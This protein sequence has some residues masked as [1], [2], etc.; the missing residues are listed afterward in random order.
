MPRTPDPGA[1]QYDLRAD[2]VTRRRQPASR[3]F[4]PTLRKRL[5]HGRSAYAHLAGSTRIHL[6]QLSP[7]ARSLVPEFGKERVPSGVVDR[8]GQYS[9][10]KSFDVQVFQRAAFHHDLSRWLVERY[11]LIA[12]EDLNIKG[13]SRGILAGPVH[14]AGWNSFFAKLWYKAASAGRELVK[15]DPRGT[16]QVCVCG[17]A[18]PKTLAERWHEC[19]ACGLSAPRDVVSAQVILQRAR[20]GRSRHNVEDVAS[21]VPREAVAFQATE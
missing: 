18:V 17:A 9:A 19:P 16:S 7:G 20:I 8:A 2:H 4:M 5:G 11:G 3:A 6:H 15:V 14:D 10:R 13:L 1:L 12:V 21:C